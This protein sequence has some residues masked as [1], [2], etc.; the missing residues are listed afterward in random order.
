MFASY[1][2]L[3]YRTGASVY[4]RDDEDAGRIHSHR[5]SNFLPIQE[6]LQEYMDDNEISI[7]TDPG[8]E[9]YYFGIEHADAIIAILMEGETG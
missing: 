8:H 2:R 9:D 4:F 1:W 3:E 5:V 6:T 7:A